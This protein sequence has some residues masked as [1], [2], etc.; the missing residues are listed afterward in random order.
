MILPT[1]ITPNRSLLWIELGLTAIAVAS[2]F[3]WPRLGTGRFARIERAF[4]RLAD[5]KRSLV[6]AGLSVILLRLALLPLFPVPLPFVP[7]DFSFLLAADTFDHG[8][9]TN[10]TPAMWIHFESIHITMRPTYQSMYFPGHGLLLALG[11]ALFGNPWY[12]LLVAD[13]FMCMGLLWMLQ[14]WIPRK[15]ALLGG[16]IAIFR[17][18]LFSNWINTYHTGGLLAALAGALVLGGLPRLMRTGRFRYGL[19][20]GIGIAILVLTRPYEGFLLCLPV[21]VM[22]VH[23]MWKGKNR[24]K[25]AAMARLAAAPLALV[26]AAGTWMGYYDYRAFGNPLTLP[27][28]VDRQTYA[29]APYYVWQL[30]RPA[31]V[32][33]HAEMRNF[34]QVLEMELFQGVHSFKWFLSSFLIKAAFTLLFY[35]GFS[36]LPPFLMARRILLDRRIRFLVLCVLVLVGGLAI[37]I[38]LLPYYVAP[39][40][41]AFY[42]IGLQAMRH[43]RLWKSEGKPVGLAMVRFTMTVC[44]V[45]FGL[46]V[47]AE[48]LHLAP[49]EWDSGNWNLNW[50]GPQHFGTERAHIEAWLEQQP[51][52]QLVI[53]RYYGNHYPVDEWVYNRAD[54][55][56]SKVVW[57][58]EMGTADNL[59]LFHYYRDRQVWLVEPDAIPAR[60][61]PY[62]MAEQT[63]GK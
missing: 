31:P 13:G 35:A 47:F 34:Y 53:V 51:G 5:S 2:A 45:M 57:A 46:R 26:I 4:A 48:P 16:I 12:I 24:L 42:A 9:L 54:I 40:T 59:E 6:Y 25:L 29:I 10:P 21:A 1:E 56:D 63:I 49:P 41:A 17:L 30:A 27:Y 3:A 33:R 39:F 61:S 38:Y 19:L 20:M 37:E 28:T 11:Q 58:H 7:D 14:A 44:V 15:W 55:D 22:L 23:W 52:R 18:G 60:V 50:F 8:R 36:L 62:P 43:L 32:Y